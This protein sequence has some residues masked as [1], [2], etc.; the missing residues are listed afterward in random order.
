VKLTLLGGGGGRVERAGPIRTSAMYRVQEA[1]GAR[2]KD[3]AGWRVADVYTSLE[4]EMARAR[5]GVGLCDV[6]AC[7]KLGIRGDAVEAWAPK[8]TAGA[9]TSVGHASWQRVNGASVL[10][11]RRAADELLWLTS[12]REASLVTAALE[13]SVESGGCVHVTDLT[14]A[15][16][17]VDLMGDK[18]AALLER[19]VALDLS[20]VPPLGVVQGD[21]AHVHAILVRLDGNALPLFRV[22]VA[23]E[24]GDF[25]WRTLSDAGHDLGLTPVGAAAHSRLTSA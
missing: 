6:S 22:L 5:S 14:A 8:L 7:G 3:D 19:L 23:R 17:V 16:A 20:A 12:A 24:Y 11:C 21:L 10:V 25:V 15:F 2:F 4:D 18:L 9:A 1:L 13:A